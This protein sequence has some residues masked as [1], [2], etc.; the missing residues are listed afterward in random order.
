M[1]ILNALWNEKGYIRP[2]EFRRFCGPTVPLLRLERMIYSAGDSLS[3]EAE[4]AHYG[5]ADLP[6]GLLQWDI[7]DDKGIILLSGNLN[8]P[9]LPT[10]DLHPLGTLQARLPEV[11]TATRLLISL[12]AGEHANSWDLWLYPR[13][14]LPALESNV[15][16]RRRVN[17][18]VIRALEEGAAVLLTAERGSIATS[19]GGH[20]GLGFSSIF[21]NTAWT[22]GQKPHTL[23]ILCRPEHP[24]LAAFPTEYHS[25][26]QWWDLIHKG[27]VV[28]MG[29]T[30]LKSE[31]IVRAIDDWFSN[32]SLG[33][34]FEAR[35]GKG[36]I[37]FTGFD[38]IEDAEN[39]P[40]ARQLMHSLVQYMNSDRFDPEEEID[41]RDLQAL[42]Q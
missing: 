21:W 7:R 42:Q 18:E 32:R 28:L 26:W 9:A 19:K 39:R 38:L 17:A 8:M 16:V 6:A 2:E 22:L 36:R 34:I 30:R 13:K 29:E 20:V 11:D 5:A 3:A 23:G 27:Q 4:L 15:I 10:G 31:P 25:N 41:L 24:A 12:K 14:T 40:V 1:G 35:A 37:L 33:L